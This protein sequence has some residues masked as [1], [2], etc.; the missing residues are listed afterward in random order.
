MGYAFALEFHSEDAEKLRELY[1]SY[2][3][4]LNSAYRRKVIALA[5]EAAILIQ[6]LETKTDWRDQKAALAA[7]STL[8][9]AGANGLLSR[10]CQKEYEGTVNDAERKAYEE[11]TLQAKN[12]GWPFVTE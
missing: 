9:V 7:L 11:K 12:F 2:V 6:I 8:A 5:T 1:V 3:K 4:Y 10:I